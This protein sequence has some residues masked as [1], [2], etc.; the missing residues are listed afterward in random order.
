MDRDTFAKSF[1]EE[2]KSRGKS[3]E[4]AIA[5]LDKALVMYD[6]DNKP[7]AETQSSLP[8]G[9]S[10]E[11][12]SKIQNIRKATIAGREQPYSPGQYAREATAAKSRNIEQP[13]GGIQRGLETAGKVAEA[14][15]LAGAGMLGQ[16]VGGDKASAALTGATKAGTSFIREGYQDISGRQESF[17]TQQAI[18]PLVEGATAAVTDYAFSKIL[19]GAKTV[20][21]K[22]RELPLI[23][24]LFGKTRKEA[25]AAEIVAKIGDDNFG[26]LQNLYGTHPKEAFISEGFSSI[27]WWQQAKGKFGNI[28]A[29]EKLAYDKMDEAGKVIEPLL[30]AADKTKKVSPLDIKKYIGNGGYPETFSLADRAIVDKEVKEII[31]NLPKNMTPSEV[32]KLSQDMAQGKFTPKGKMTSLPNEVSQAKVSIALKN[33]VKENVEGTAEQISQQHKM[34]LWAKAIKNLSVKAQ[35]QF[36]KDVFGGL[37]A[38]EL[39]RKGAQVALPAGAIAYGQQNNNPVATGLGALGLALQAPQFA[40]EL[41]GGPAKALYKESLG[42]GMVKKAT[43]EIVK[44]VGRVGFLQAI[45]GQGR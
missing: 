19:N 7:K 21:A 22:T 43:G 44:Q 34:F 18:S 5:G 38:T 1:L 37:S 35:K 26:K 23:S 17:G 36:G 24:S 8:E 14:G 2:A 28:S 29:G 16:A 33:W 4:E 42:P 30:K 27:P 31:S 11:Q 13:K 41:A 10:Q 39:A 3:K 32:M 45:T 20:L 12:Y 25:L 9:V 6:A 15:L 40:T